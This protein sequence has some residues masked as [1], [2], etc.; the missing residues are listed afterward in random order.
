MNFANKY[1]VEFYSHFHS[2]DILLDMFPILCQL[3]VGQC[4]DCFQLSF[5]WETQVVVRDGDRLVEMRGL[6]DERYFSVR[7]SQSGRTDV[8]CGCDD[9]DEC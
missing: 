4:L 5:P 7:E 6:L 2:Y 8:E 3:C 1:L 9:G